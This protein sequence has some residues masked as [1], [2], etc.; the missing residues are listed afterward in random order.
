MEL[1]LLERKLS[2]AVL[3]GESRGD[4]CSLT[5]LT[6]KVLDKWAYENAVTLDFIRPGKPTDNAYIESFNGSLRDECLNS[7]W[8]MSLEDAKQKIEAWRWEYNLIRLHYALGFMTPSE[9]AEAISLF[10]ETQSEKSPDSQIMT[11]T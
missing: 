6:S 10:K 4:A 3:R 2:R 8:F 1:E 11:G 7:H 5:R 9:F